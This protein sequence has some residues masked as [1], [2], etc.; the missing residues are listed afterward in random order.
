M[1]HMKLP[2]PFSSAIIEGLAELLVRRNPGTTSSEQNEN[3]LGGETRSI[4]IDESMAKPPIYEY[5]E[6]KGNPLGHGSSKPKIRNIIEMSGI[7]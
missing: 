1:P 4:S 3:S 6:A 5:Y 2:S 7:T